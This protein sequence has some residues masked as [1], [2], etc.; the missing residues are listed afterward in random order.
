M[1]KSYLLKYPWVHLLNG[2][3]DN[4]NLIVMIPGK[5]NNDLNESNKRADSDSEFQISSGMEEFLS[6]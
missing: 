6:V 1:G 3:M 2:L 4:N 5:R